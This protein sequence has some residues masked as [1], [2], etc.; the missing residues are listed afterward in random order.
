MAYNNDTKQRLLDSA[1][2]LFSQKGYNAASV[3]EIAAAAGIKGPSM[4]KYFTGKEALFYELHNISTDN[5]KERMN[6][7]S[8]AEVSIH[9][10]EQLKEFSMKQVRFTMTDEKG[11]KLRRM[12]THEQFRSK[13]LSEAATAR[14]FTDIRDFFAGIMK[15][16]ISE[17]LI[18]ENDPQWLASVYTSTV[19]LLIQ[20][21]DREPER[22][23]ELIKEVEE[24]IDRFIEHFFI[25]K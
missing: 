10:A 21:S 23:E 22:V 16:L 19:S 14:Q 8:G 1:L 20:I 12:F 15:G 2:E 13:T 25:K 9:S 4:Y 3:D 11:R 18:A 7:G 5:Y 6:M 24:F 17:G